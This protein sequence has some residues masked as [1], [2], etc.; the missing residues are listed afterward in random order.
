MSNFYAGDQ[1][2]TFVSS[3]N[4][5]LPLN[6]VLTVVLKQYNGDCS[7]YF[8]L[9]HS[10][11]NSVIFCDAHLIKMDIFD[12]SP[13]VGS[14]CYNE[15]LH[16]MTSISS[17]LTLFSTFSISC[18]YTCFNFIHIIIGSYVY[19]H[20]SVLLSSLSYGCT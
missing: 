8:C 10:V 18:E 15:P 2:C 12:R 11:T 6:N 14:L 20:Y 19:T 17:Y 13:S 4:N 9:T 5:N 16:L 7:M 3:T 1:T